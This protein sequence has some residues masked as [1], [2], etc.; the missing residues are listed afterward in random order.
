MEEAEVSVAAGHT[1]VNKLHNGVEMGSSVYH[2]H[3]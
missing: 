2:V 1:D 3:T